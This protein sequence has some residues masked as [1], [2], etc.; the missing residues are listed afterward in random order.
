MGNTA[1][2]TKDAAAR[3]GHRMNEKTPQKV[4]DLGGGGFD[5]ALAPVVQGVVHTLELLN[6]W[7]VELND[8]QAVIKHHQSRGE[9]VNSLG[10]VGELDLE[11]LD[12]FTRGMVLRW[13][14]LGAGE[15][16]SLG[17]LAMI[18][19]PVVGAAAAIS[20]DMV[21]MQVLSAAIATRVCHAYGFDASDP[22]LRHMIDRMVVRSYRQQVPKVGVVKNAGAAFE[23]AKGRVN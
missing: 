7:V 4:K 5:M 20:V 3:A 17:A 22:E 2:A 21:A 13:R 23:A 12:N 16:A 6:D 19:V 11:H 10:D 18:P 8:P 14:T 9:D 1:K 15:G